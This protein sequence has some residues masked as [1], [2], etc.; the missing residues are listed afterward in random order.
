MKNETLKYIWPLILGPF[1][2]VGIS[3]AAAIAVAAVARSMARMPYIPLQSDG[4]IEMDPRR[5]KTT[6]HD[7][8]SNLWIKTL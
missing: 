3:S 6:K 4:W 1:K 7:V 2:V 5:K 8:V